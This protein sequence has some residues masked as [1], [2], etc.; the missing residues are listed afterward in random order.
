MCQGQAVT[1]SALGQLDTRLGI[2]FAEAVL[3]LLKETEL[4]AQDITAIGCH[5]QT[6]WHEPTGDAPCTL[7]IGDNNRVAA[8]TGITTVGDFRRRDLAYGGQGAPLVP[9][10]H[11]ALLLHPVE[12]R[13][14]LN[15]GGI[16]NLSLLVRVRPCA[17][18]IP[19]PE[20]CCWMPGSGGIVH[21]RMIKTPCGR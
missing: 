16:A 10:F 17:V 4:R 1:L 11:H 2:L 6:V 20:I 21:N 5:G 3:T 9:S 8:L 14:V 15:I 13:I 18:T 19:V 7:Q 12:R